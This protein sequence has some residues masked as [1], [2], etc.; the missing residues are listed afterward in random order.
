MHGG[1]NF[2]P[3]REQFAHFL[4]SPS[5]HYMETYNASE[6]FFGIQ[7]DLSSKD[8]LLMLDL[9]IFYE[10]IPIDEIHSDNPRTVLLED[11]EI[12]KNY[13]ML[14]STNSGLWRYLIGDTI[15]FT[16]RY[17]FKI[18]ITGRTKHFINAFGEELIIDNAERALQV[19]C[20]RTNAQI[21]DYTAAPVFM[22][23]DSKGAHQWLIEWERE[24]SDFQ[25][26]T[27]LLD[28]ELKS[29]NSDY[30]AKR[31]KNMTL[32]EPQLVS[33]RNGTFYQ[34]LKQKGK[35]GGQNKIPRLSN[36]RDYADE[37]YSIHS[38]L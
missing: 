15:S 30:E 28:C 12:G 20:Q 16:S 31:Y 35:L 8:M 33:L 25:H 11:V 26:F 3:Y 36:T 6:G 18:K 2:T 7:N 27:E 14:I 13:A 19:A 17:P 23:S 9:G 1:V 21:R 24:P 29:L 32:T 34:W 37:I 10:F 4:P 38:S 22:S 5:M